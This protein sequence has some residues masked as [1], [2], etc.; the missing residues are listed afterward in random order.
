[1][2]DQDI[3][4]MKMIDDKK[5]CYRQIKKTVACMMQGQDVHT[6]D[7]VRVFYKT[8]SILLLDSTAAGSE[9]VSVLL[10]LCVKVKVKLERLYNLVLSFLTPC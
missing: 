4:L 5:I 7:L 6:L 10:L 3:S 9:E 8:V 2:I 1:M